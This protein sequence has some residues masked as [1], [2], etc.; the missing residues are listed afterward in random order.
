MSI[1]KVRSG[2]LWVDTDKTGSVRYQGATEPYAPA[3]GPSTE[4][5]AWPSEPTLTDGNDNENY[6]M[7]A[8]FHLLQGK[9]CY[10]VRWKVPDSV[11]NPSSGTH[12]VALW[13]L[14]PL[15]LAYKTFTPVPGGY[16]D[17]LFDTPVALLA[18]PVEYV[19]S[20]LTRHYSFR[21]PSPTSGWLVESPSLNIRH[22][23]SKLSA[24]SDPTTFPGGAFSAWYYVS[25]IMEL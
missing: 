18:A 25:P 4:T 19:V 15:R 24:S 12:A 20:V 1:M 11:E 14:A 21:T 17:I 2:G 9:L 5:L 23:L 3:G 22:D 7:G 10:G 16:Q 13:D 8:Q 6:V